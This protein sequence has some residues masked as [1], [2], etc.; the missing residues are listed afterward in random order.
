VSR[1]AP[2]VGSH[3]REIVRLAVPAFLALIAEPLFLLADS[4]IIG[5]LGTAELAGLGVASAAL[6]TAAGVFVF[7]AYGTTSVVARHLGAGDERSAVS[8]GIDGL[9]L[10][11]GLGAGTAAGVAVWAGPI[12]AI[13]GASP[14]VLE[15]ATTY[16]RISAL[17][18]PAMLAVLAVTGVL[19]GLQDTTTPLVASVVGFSANIALNLVFVYGLHWGIAGSA[20]GTVIAQTGMGVALVTVLLVKARARHARLRPHPA[21]VLAAGRTGIPLLVRTLALR[22]TLLVTT[23]VAASLGD[24]PLAAHQVAM[25][26]WTFLAFALDALAIAAQAITGRAL[27]G[28]DRAGVRLAMRTM[29]RW[30]VWGGLALGLVIAALHTVLPPLFTPDPAVQ[31]ALGAALVVVGHG[32][33]VAGYVFVLDGVLI[34]AGDGRW[35]AGGQVA[36]LVAYLPVILAVREA[37]PS[38][39][40]TRDVVVLWVAFTAF[41]AIR[42]V[43]LGWRARRDDWM[44]VGAR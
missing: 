26:V 19:R 38:G 28:G 22:A 7:L 42:G 2:A 41:M 18:I 25:T 5:H 6:V 17:G 24:V 15:Q 11:L 35:L 32:Q 39:S 30:G 13:L 43:V 3:R 33:A 31:E 21:R 40:A 44:V 36:T 34:G 14:A 37:G 20:W 8:A 27:G 4:A 9:W 1:T 12:S 23:W 10:A 29:V 16:L